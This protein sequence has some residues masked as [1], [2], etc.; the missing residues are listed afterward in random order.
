MA[1]QAAANATAMGMQHRSLEI[2]WGEAP[3]PHKPLSSTA[4][5]R[6]A[7]EARYH[8]L[9]HGMTQAGATAVAFGHHADDQVETSLMRLAKGSTEIGAAGMRRCRRW[10]MGS[11]SSEDG[12]GWVGH[13]GLDR[14]IVRPLLDFSKVGHSFISN[15]TVTL[16]LAKDRILATCEAHALDYVN[17]PTNFQPGVTLR[18]AVRQAL[19]ADSFHAGGPLPS[20]MVDSLEIVRKAA[21]SLQSTVADVVGVRERLRRAT[22]FLA[23]RAEEIDNQVTKHLQSCS[24]PSPRGTILLSSSGLLE[25]QDP[26]VRFAIVLRVMR[27]VSF[28]PWGSIRADGDRRRASIHRIMK[29]LWSHDPEPA[30]LKKFTAGGGVLWTP[31]LYHRGKRLKTVHHAQ[32]RGDGDF[33]W[34]ASRIPPFF[35]NP[36]EGAGS[37]SRLMVDLT[38]QFNMAL[39]TPENNTSHAMVFEVLYDCRF[40]LRFDLRQMPKHVRTALNNA[41]AEQV[42]LPPDIHP[43]PESVTPYFVYP[44]TLEPHVL[45]LEASRRS[46]LAAHAARQA[47]VL[48]AHEDEKEHRKREALRRVAPGFEGNGAVLMP[49]RVSSDPSNDETKRQIVSV[50]DDAGASGS[51][52]GDV[53][54]GLADQLARLSAQKYQRHSIPTFRGSGGLWSNYTLSDLATPQAF[55]RDPSKVW[56][57][58]H[59]R[60]ETAGKAVPNTAHL[61]LALFSQPERR[62]DIA[63]NAEFTLITQNV[64]GLSVLCHQKVSPSIEPPIIEMHGRLFET[65]C[66]ECGDRQPNRDSPICPALAGTEQIVASHSK[67]RDIALEDLPRCK[68]CSGLLRPGVVWFEE[69]ILRGSDIFE[70]VDK[71]DVA[72]VIGTSSQVAPANWFAEEVSNRKGTVAVFNIEEPQGGTVHFFFPGPCE[73]TLPR[74]LL[75]VESEAIAPIL[76][77]N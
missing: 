38:E 30:L 23:E 39:S 43:L 63:P 69:N 12:L 75:G 42:K 31:V 47:A 11:G 67:E 73:Q 32:H 40:L 37:A 57:F 4:F 14:F 61:A 62:E 54:D 53:M 3:F 27:Y 26:S 58:Y 66:T 24:L 71:A 7:R 76:H 17:D 18:N 45:R 70:L 64:D 22:S 16:T 1:A 51:Q 20:D 28:H 2:P 68:K 48:R 56:Q 15:P 55:K 65:L 6:H 19:D 77:Q 35:K 21:T 50:G 13:R 41:H 46:T 60:R 33:A 72:L 52:A 44:F 34:L 10:G 9:F 29:H 8:V 36:Q 74:V 25:V 49:V 59:Y 5:E